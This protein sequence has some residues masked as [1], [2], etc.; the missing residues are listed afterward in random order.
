LLDKRFEP[1][2]KPITIKS[3]FSPVLQPKYIGITNGILS[4][5]IT[6]K[7]LSFLQ[8]P[9]EF[10]IEHTSDNRTH[11]E[12]KEAYSR[13][14]NANNNTSHSFSCTSIFGDKHLMHIEFVK[15]TPPKFWK[16][17]RKAFFQAIVL[18]SETL[19]QKNNRP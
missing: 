12:V 10:T 13:I 19:I 6:G 1:S 18:E 16:V 2:V 15:P 17:I 14:I 3:L 5:N 11:L 4:V 9:P 8:I 7:Y